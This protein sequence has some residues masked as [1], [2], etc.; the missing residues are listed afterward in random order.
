MGLIIKGPPIPRVFPPFALWFYRFF[1][2][3]EVFCYYQGP[4]RKGQKLVHSTGL[5]Y[6]PTFTVIY[7]R[8]GPFMDRYI[9]P[10][11]IIATSHDRFSPNGALVREIPLFQG[12]LGW[13]NIIIWPDIPVPLSVWVCFLDFFLFRGRL[14]TI[15]REKVLPLDPWGACGF[16]PKFLSSDRDIFFVYPISI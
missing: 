14:V 8:N 1:T 15:Y 3:G 4:F 10:G 12:N 6:F 2:C 13:W 5:V 16:D 11:Q 9:Y 7:H